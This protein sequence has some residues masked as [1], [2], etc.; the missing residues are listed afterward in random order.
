MT[1]NLSPTVGRVRVTAPIAN[2]LNRLLQDGEKAK[3]L[4]VRLEEELLGDDEAEV[5]EGEDQPAEGDK[6]DENKVAG[7]REKGSD[8]VEDH[9]GRLLEH[10]GLL[11]E[12][13]SEEQRIRKVSQVH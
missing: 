5:K 10:E 8:M 13:L 7:L 1:V 6:A 3:L 4:A 9:I 11:S 12:D 2:T